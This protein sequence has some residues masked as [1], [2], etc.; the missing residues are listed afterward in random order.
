MAT[1]A[2]AFVSDVAMAH[3]G[4]FSKSLMF[5]ALCI[6]ENWEAHAAPEIRDMRE[7]NG[8]VYWL[9]D[10][11]VPELAIIIDGIWHGLTEECRDNWGA[12]DFEFV[13]AMMSALK[14][15]RSFGNL[16]LNLVG[17]TIDAARTF[18]ESKTPWL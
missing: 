3:S 7:W 8:G 5:T 6:W 14:P 16:G 9:R 11:V 4:Y 15:V 17:W 12:F 1:Q 10:A 2:E 13:P 18:A